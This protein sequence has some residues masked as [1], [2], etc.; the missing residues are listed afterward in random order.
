MACR[1]FFF[2]P[3]SR[4]AF[5]DWLSAQGDLLCVWHSLHPLREAASPR[6]AD[7]ISIMLRQL[8]PCA[9]PFSA[10]LG[11]ANA[12][13]AFPWTTNA[14]AAFLGTTRACAR[15]EGCGT[16]EASSSD[17]CWAAPTGRRT[18]RGASAAKHDLK[19]GQ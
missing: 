14:R 1:Q 4:V 5:G 7:I 11:T 3:V 2:I 8:R 13:A 15:V 9:R 17:A 6:K 19:G 16:C 12:R 18:P 10:V